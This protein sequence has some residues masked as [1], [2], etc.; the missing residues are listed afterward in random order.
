M[1]LYLRKSIQRNTNDHYHT[2]KDLEMFGHFEGDCTRR[3]FR[4]SHLNFV[5]V[6]F[7]YFYKVLSS[8]QWIG[9][10]IQCRVKITFTTRPIGTIILRWLRIQIQKDKR[11]DS[12][13]WSISKVIM[14]YKRIGYNFNVMRQSACLVINPITIDNFA[15]LL[16]C[17]PEDRASDYMMAPDLKLFILVGWDLSFRLLLG[18]PGLN[19]WSSFASDSQWCWLLVFGISG[20]PELSSVAKCNGGSTDVFLLL[21]ISSGVVWRFIGFLAVL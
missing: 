17:T 12:F 21:Q 11:Y 4:R 16:N 15:A 18:P 13:F 2:I 20:R 7:K 1:R 6:V 8:T 3:A 10:K 5:S 9:Y 14:R 19:W